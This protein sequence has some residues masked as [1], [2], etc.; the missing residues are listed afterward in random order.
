MPVLG[1]VER[2]ALLVGLRISATATPTGSEVGEVCVV[3]YDDFFAAIAGVNEATLARPALAVLRSQKI[4]VLG[5]LYP[6]API[7][8]GPEAAM[9]FP[10]EGRRSVRQKCV[11]WYDDLDAAVAALE[12]AALARPALAQSRVIQE[13]VGWNVDYPA[14]VT[15]RAITA[16]AIPAA[17]IAVLGQV[18]VVRGRYG[19]AAIP[20]LDVAAFAGP[21]PAVTTVQE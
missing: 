20:E 9:A 2:N 7:A 18:G 8:G 13:G 10:L 14:T 3:G 16:Q 15:D 21:P 19:L 12:E 17:P 1:D 6:D 5:N 4:A 11:F